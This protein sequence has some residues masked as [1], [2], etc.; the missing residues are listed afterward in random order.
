MQR[1][2]KSG[3]GAGGFTLV[4]LIVV[5]AIVAVLAG[6]LMLAI[7]PAALLAKSRAAN[8][9]EDLDV[10]NMAITLALAEG[11]ITLGAAGPNRSDATGALDVDG[12]GYVAFTIPT[13]KTGLSKYVSTLPADPINGANPGGGADLVYTFQSTATNWEM[14]CVLESADNLTKMSTDGGNDANAYE[15]GTSLVIIT[16]S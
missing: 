9:L 15:I 6:V 14:N 3:G 12:T 13:G 5:I 16:P 4:E 1:I 8:R 11:E 10:L 7:N 2:R